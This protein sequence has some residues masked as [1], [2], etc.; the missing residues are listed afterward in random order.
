MSRLRF[1]F[2]LITREHDYQQQQASAALAAAK[3]LGE[4][5]DIVYANNDPITKSTEGYSGGTFGAAQW[6]YH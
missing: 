5:G 6:N 1:L 3:D 2:S 4:D